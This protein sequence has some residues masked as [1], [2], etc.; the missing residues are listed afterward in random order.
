MIA[1]ID[2]ESTGGTIDHSGVDPTRFIYWAKVTTTVPNQVV[3][4]SQTN[5]STNNTPRFTVVQGWARLFEG[6]NCCVYKNGTV[7]DSNTGVSFTVKKP[8][9]YI[10]GVKYDAKVLYGK[11][12]PVPPTITYN[13]TT[14]LGG[15]ASVLLGPE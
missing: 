9:S 8:G 15:A 6:D 7:I 12:V 14:S 2:Y 1:K 3:T 10:I 11:P 13:F 4:V 5:T